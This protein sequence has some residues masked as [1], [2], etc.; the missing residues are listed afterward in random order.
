MIFFLKLGFR[1]NLV[2]AKP[3]MMHL[4]STGSLVFTTCM[5]VYLLIS[6][7]YFK[8]NFTFNYLNDPAVS[9]SVSP[10]EL[11]NALAYICIH[12]L[13]TVSVGKE[14]CSFQFFS[15]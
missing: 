15:Q 2:G 11:L 8:H 6:L 9:I 13:E 14:K 4:G 1:G 10:S 12:K 5:F 7:I 3:L